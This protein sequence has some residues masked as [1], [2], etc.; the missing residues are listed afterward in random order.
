VDL[1]ADYAAEVFGNPKGGKRRGTVFGGLARLALEVDLDKTVGWRE[2]TFKISTIYSH[3]TSGSLQNVGDAAFFSSIDAYDSLRLLDLSVE[4][5]FMEG[6]AAIR[7]GQM[8]VDTEFGVTDTAAP[9]INASYGVPSPPVTPM[10]YAAYPAAG[11]GIRLKVEPA[12]GWY[13]M[14]GIYDGNP[15][16]GD[17]PD[18]SISGATPGAARR[19]GTDWA[20]RASEGAFYAT[21][22]GFQRTDGALPGAYRAGFL[23]HSDDFADVRSGVT[24]TNRG[25]AS[26]YFVLE[27]TLW[28]K[29]GSSKEGVA[30]FLR[31][32]VADEKT[33]Y[34]SKAFQ[35]GAVYTG[36]LTGE[37]RIG[38]AFGR[39]TFSAGQV[40]TIN[41]G[42]YRLSR[43][44]FAE[45]TYVFPLN[46]CLRVQPDLQYISRP[47]GATA[48][49]NAWILGVRATLEF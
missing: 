38:L 19:H 42:D 4:Q 34:M 16:S 8:L 32:T 29:P 45:L 1:F 44:S 2:A 30:A 40:A 43:E 14:A 33:G 26:G 25:S 10:P 49:Q 15:S 28:Q 21:E 3:G 39:S 37:D 5:R 31:G 35:A 36:F 47:G 17:Y 22:V 27:Q 11:L 12:K 48:F 9:F 18:P 6:R 13:G 7:V 24:A 20:L 41:G 23:Y 46:S